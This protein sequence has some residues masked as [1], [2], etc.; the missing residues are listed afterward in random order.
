MAQTKP[1]Y[2]VGV[3]LGGTK[4][5]SGVFDESL[6][7]VDKHKVSTKARRGPDAVIQRILR[8]VLDAVDECDLKIDQ[9][10]AVGI[11]APGVVNPESGKVIF[12]PNLA[13]E[14][15][16]LKKELEKRLERPVHV[17]NDCNLCALGVHAVEL[18]GKPDPMIGIFLGTGIGGGLIIN[19]ALHSGFNRTAGEVGHMVIDVN[20]PKC[21]CGKR[22]CFEALAGRASIFR[23]IQVAVNEG[24]KT[25]LTEITG[26][27]L[28]QLR[29][30]SLKKAIKAGDPFVIKVIE[31][32]SVYTGI[33]VANLINILSP[34]V[35]VLGGGVM[36][37]LEDSMLPLITKTAHSYSMAGTTTGVKIIAS[38]L[39]DH[40]GITGGAVL[41]R[42]ESRRASTSS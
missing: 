23:R 5:L 21:S 25:M 30:G 39:G 35:V 26:G 34:E 12:A 24:Q 40:A 10:A 28:A 2:Y 32:A 36:D 17:E 42:A 22:G 3:D 18:N 14:G 31:E 9:I 8:C 16:A 37:A 15:V 4:I 1:N 33:A 13:W 19:G 27:D 38:H 29:S 20:G 41:A 6:N 11:G 7:P